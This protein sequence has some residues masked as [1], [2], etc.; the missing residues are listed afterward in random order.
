MIKRHLPIF[1]RL[2]RFAISGGLSTILY[3]V[4]AV[5]FG[6]LTSFSAMTSHI[7][8][9]ILCVPVSYLLQRNFTFKHKGNHKIAVPKF[10][11]AF[12][13]AFAI[14]TITVEILV[15]NLGFAKEIGTISV[16]IIVPIVSYLTMQLWVFKAK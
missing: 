1:L 8:A 14:S 7:V 16:M 6:F 12:I 4:F 5:L 10:I 13:A 11:T 3:G 15:N 9:Y 2:I